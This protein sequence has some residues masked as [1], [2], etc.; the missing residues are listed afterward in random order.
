MKIF[1]QII[2]SLMLAI[3]SLAV[4]NNASAFERTDRYSSMPNSSKS[5]VRGLNSY[6]Q[7][8]QRGKVRSRS[9]VMREVKQRY[10]AEVLRIKLNE[11][12]MVYEVRV[13]LPNGKVKNITVGAR[14]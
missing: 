9:E 13:L 6:A 2:F 12:R 8:S 14:G 10:Q 7:R 5:S 4:T 11:R 3:A 1:V